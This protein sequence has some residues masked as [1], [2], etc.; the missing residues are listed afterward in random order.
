MSDPPASSAADTRLPTFV[1]MITFAPMVDSECTRLVLTHYAIAFEEQDHVF[2]WA[3]L[4]TLLHGGY[5]RIPLVHG[6]GIHASGPRAVVEKLDPLAGDRRL[7]PTDPKLRAQVEKD[8]AIYNGQLAL[9]V[10]AFAYYHLLPERDAM[11]AAFRSELS[12]VEQRMAAPSYGMVRWMLRMLLRLSPQR[13][14]DALD[15]VRAIL[16]QTDERVRDGRRCLA[17]EAVTLADLGF[18]GAIAPLALP[19][20]YLKHVP[21]FELLPEAYRAAVEETR[22]RPAAA[23]LDRLLQSIVPAAR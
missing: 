2:G 11:I 21:P 16:D 17:G 12:G 18:A 4:L 22:A 5:G 1:K 7:L 9:H 6:R 15:R 20:R 3:S 19:K 10:A 13:A 14:A 23:F 8:W